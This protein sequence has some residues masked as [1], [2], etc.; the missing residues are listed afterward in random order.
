[1]TT[2]HA[3]AQQRFRAKRKEAKS[4]LHQKLITRLQHTIEDTDNTWAAAFYEEMI[5]WVEQLERWN[6]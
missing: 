3:Q 2:T 1:M 5:E 6:V 4:I